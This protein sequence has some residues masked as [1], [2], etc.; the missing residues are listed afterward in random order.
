MGPKSKK[1]TLDGQKSLKLA[2]SPTGGIERHN[3]LGK[4]SGDNAGSQIG[5]RPRNSAPLPQKGALLDLGPTGSN[6]VNFLM[7]ETALKS[8]RHNA[9]CPEPASRS[10]YSLAL[11]EE[12][13]P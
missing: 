6:L 2:D 5:K 9:A 3:L 10:A 13:V 12:Q 7:Q 11:E 8:P 4:L 1:D